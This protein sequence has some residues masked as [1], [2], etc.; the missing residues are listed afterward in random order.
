MDGADWA[1][2]FPETDVIEIGGLFLYVLHDLQNLDLDPGAAGFSAI[3][4]GHSHASWQK[5]RSGVLYFNPGSA[6]PRRLHL[7]VT[8]GRLEIEDKQV[9]GEIIQLPI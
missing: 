3:I 5:T 1:Q 2:S 6:G 8:L 4:Y 9:L 7:P